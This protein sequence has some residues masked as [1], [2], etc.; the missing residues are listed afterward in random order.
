MKIKLSKK[1][2]FSEEIDYF[3][4]QLKLACQKGYIQQRTENN[5]YLL[6]SYAGVEEKGITPKWNIKIYKFNKRNKGHSVVCVDNLILSQLLEEDYGALTPPDLDILSID[7]AGWGFPLCGVMVG[8]SDDREVKSSMVPVE[9]F[10]DDN[11]N[12]FSTNLYLKKYADLAITL[13]EGFGASPTTYRIEIC[14]GYVNQ[15]LRKKLR[16]L[17]F[18]VRVVEI[19]GLLQDKLENIY[20]KYVLEKLGADIYYDPKEMNKSEI[21]KMYYECVNF[22]LKNCPEQMKTGWKSLN[23]ISK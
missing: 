14:T 22:G 9:Y 11:K 1:I 5:K 17:G 8:V 6:A 7:D 10:R 23:G 2:L 20:K 13:I 16:E 18:D 3:L 15:P 21:S 19:K 4:A 12:E